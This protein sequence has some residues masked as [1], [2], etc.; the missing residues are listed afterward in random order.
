MQ[1]QCRMPSSD[2]IT[3]TLHVPGLK[4]TVQYSYDASIPNKQ[5]TWKIATDFGQ[6]PRRSCVFVIGEGVFGNIRPMEVWLSV[7]PPVQTGNT[8]ILCTRKT[9][10]QGQNEYY[11][12]QK[13]ALSHNT[14]L[15]PPI[16]KNIAIQLLMQIHVNF[17]LLGHKHYL[18]G[19]DLYAYQTKLGEELDQ[20][21]ANAKPSYNSL[22]VEPDQKKI[23]P[24]CKD[25]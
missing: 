23:H 9:T 16:T 6:E 11:E 4:K 15:N 17:D 14:Y 3:V 7:T 25:E 1:I 18:P 5:L 12:T 22:P 8:L 2:P 10:V 19:T 13:D 20:W 21:Y 24:Y